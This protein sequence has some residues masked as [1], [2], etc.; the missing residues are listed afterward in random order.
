MLIPTNVLPAGLCLPRVGAFNHLMF[1][2]HRKHP[3]WPAAQLQCWEVKSPK[4]PPQK[5]SFCSADPQR[6]P[7]LTHRDTPPTGSVTRRFPSWT[8]LPLWTHHWG[9]QVT[10]LEPEGLGHSCQCKHLC[11]PSRS[12]CL[13]SRHLPPRARGEEAFRAPLR[14]SEP[15][16]DW[17]RPPREAPVFLWGTRSDRPPPLI[18]T[19]L[20]FMVQASLQGPT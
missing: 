12:P 14:E 11:L 18:P 6:C 15:R 5:I 19:A 3:L 8:G 17:C 13:A 2:R 20:G 7:A 9:L 16:G 10:S 4:P 1:T